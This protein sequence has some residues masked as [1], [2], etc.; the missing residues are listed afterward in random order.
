MGIFFII[1][2]F[3]WKKL[4]SMI[5]SGFIDYNNLSFALI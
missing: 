3:K 5:F 1:I 2:A 4:Y